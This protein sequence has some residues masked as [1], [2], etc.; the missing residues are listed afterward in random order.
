M[1]ADGG[2]VVSWVQLASTTPWDLL[3]RRYDPSGAPIEDPAV[4]ARD[5]FM[6][7]PPGVAMDADGDFVV[8]W[9]RGES[10][11]QLFWRRYDNTLDAWGPPNAV[12]PGRF[13][14]ANRPAIDMD[15]GG[16]FCIVWTSGRDLD[17]FVNAQCYTAG[18]A[19][20]GGE[21]L[22]EMQSNYHPVGPTVAVDEEGDLVVTWEKHGGSVVG[23][24][25]IVARGYTGAFTGAPD[26]TGVFVG[27]T[28][29][30]P[31]FS[32]LLER[33]GQGHRTLGYALPVGMEPDELPWA[34][35]DR[36]TLSF[37]R[38][39]EVRQGD[40]AVRGVAVADYPVS[41]FSYDPTTRTA[42]WTLGRTIPADRVRLELGGDAAG[43]DGFGLALKVLPGD[44]N[45]DGRVNSLDVLRVR[46]RYGV[47][48]DD[49]A[50]PPAAPFHDLDGSNR[51]DYA[52]HVIVRRNLGSTLP[53]AA[54]VPALRGAYRSAPPLSR[55]LFAAVPIVT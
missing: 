6:N 2:F 40:L 28:A 21:I 29:W 8:L 49:P 3:A 50:A 46:Q 12:T 15:Q 54:P 53:P 55:Q 45:S 48:P 5:V 41:G 13:S 24:S 39:V 23:S 43:A 37:R 17:S 33:R 51:I 18:G 36:V 52:D 10:G 16:D 7:S 44:I 27:G 20:L 25:D 31:R 32:A 42:T 47:I 30:N 26:V 14:G 19:K 22:V 34:N 4:V 9:A 1:D 11:G 35:L 38:D